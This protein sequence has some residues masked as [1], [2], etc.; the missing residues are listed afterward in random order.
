MDR[1]NASITSS[2]KLWMKWWY[3][4]IGYIDDKSIFARLCH[5]SLNK[6][7]KWI[8]K[9]K[10]ILL[11]TLIQNIFLKTFGLNIG[12]IVWKPKR[13]KVYKLKVFKSEEVLKEIIIFCALSFLP[14]PVTEL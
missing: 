2:L 10:K 12:Q 8:G 7:D 1:R 13:I 14:H 4:E 9:L 3:F 5:N 11:S 6:Y